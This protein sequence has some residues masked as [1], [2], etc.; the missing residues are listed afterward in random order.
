MK[1]CIA[2]IVKNKEWVFS[3]VGVA[4]IAW[5]AGIFKKTRASSMQ[6]IHSGDNSMNVQAGR[7]LKIKSIK[8]NDVEQ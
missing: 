4:I 5:V 8:E 7:D 1:E 2:W 3:G 6:I